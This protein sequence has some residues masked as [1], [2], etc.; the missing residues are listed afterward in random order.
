MMDKTKEKVAH[1]PAVGVVGEQPSYMYNNTIIA[2]AVDYGNLQTTEGVSMFE[3]MG[4]QYEERDGILYPLISMEEE[5]VDVGKYGL[6]WMEYMKSEY[7]QRY[8][9]LKRCCRL[10]EKASEVNEEAYR[11]LDEITD[12]Y[13]KGNPE[14]LLEKLIDYICVIS[15]VFGKKVFVLVNIKSYFTK[16]E[17]KLLYKKMFYEKI[18]LLLIENHDNNDIIEEE[19]VTIIDKD[20]CVINKS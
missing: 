2:D 12:K 8:V 11:I 3:R 18:Y 6:L 13:L 10:R 1:T 4:G 14:N 19:R 16:D 15:E 17:L 7:L 9:S 5:H 20:M